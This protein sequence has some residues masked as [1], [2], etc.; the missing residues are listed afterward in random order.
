M[1]NILIPV[2][3]VL[4]FSCGSNESSEKNANANENVASKNSDQFNTDF[5]NMLN[6]YYHLKDGLVLSYDTTANT[7]NGF[8]TLLANNADS[9][10][11]QDVQIDSLSKTTAKTYLTSI[12]SDAKA[13][14]QEK[15]LEEKRK[16]FSTITESMYELIRVVRYDQAKVYYINCPMAFDDKGGNWLNNSDDVKNP[17]FGRKMLTCG[18]VLDSLDYKGK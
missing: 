9:I 1:K 18:V 5:A 15:D 4:L 17:Y 13:M 2:I 12:S 10:E 3:A 14:V 6:N 16:S 8:A 11:L 7:V